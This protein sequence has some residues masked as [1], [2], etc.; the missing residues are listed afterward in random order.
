MTIG[1]IV[2]IAVS[3]C[4]VMMVATV[5]TISVITAWTRHSQTVHGAL[6]A[7]TIDTNHPSVVDVKACEEYAER[8]AHYMTDAGT[9][10]H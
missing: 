4:V 10:R 6:L 5:C 9:T 3:A 8:I 7:T 1:L 2:A